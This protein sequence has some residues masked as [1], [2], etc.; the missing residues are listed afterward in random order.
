[1]KCELLKKLSR[2]KNAA[3]EVWVFNKLEPWW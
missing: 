2:V 3:T 1:L